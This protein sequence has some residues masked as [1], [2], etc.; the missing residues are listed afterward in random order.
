VDGAD[1]RDID[2]DLVDVRQAAALIGRHPETIRRW[3][4][5]GRIG[6]RRRGNRLFVDRA[7]VESVAGA[8]TPESRSL[9]AWAQ[10]AKELREVGGTRGVGVSAADLVLDDRAERSRSG[11]AGR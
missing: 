3:V 6:A 2:A 5:S 7:D 10:R 8:W 11:R 4:W 9:E 1:R